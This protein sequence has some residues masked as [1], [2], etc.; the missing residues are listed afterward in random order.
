VE[1]V[2][3]ITSRGGFAAVALSIAVMCGQSMAD[4]VSRV[5]PVMALRSF[6]VEAVRLAI[7]D[8]TSTFGVKYPSGRRSL[9]DLDKL[10]AVRGAM[11]KS[12]DS[13]NRPPAK[14]VTDMLVR[15]RR[16]RREALL[17]NP[18]LEFDKLMLLKRRRGQ[19][20]LPVNHMCNSGLKP[21]GYDNEIAVLSPVGP[22]GKLDTLYR[23][24]GGE[25]VGEIDLHLN[26]DRLLFTMP[27]GKAWQV[28][29]INT[30]GS[31]LRQVSRGKDVGVD[32]FDAC[33]LPDGRIVFASTASWHAVPCWHGKQR[34]CSLY[35]MKADSSAVRQLCFDQDLDLHPAVLPSG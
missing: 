21:G 3:K 27:A 25:Y 28:F 13:G 31:G 10:A 14:A 8:I 33:Y 11:L 5:D 24:K 12:F 30:N 9:A 19:L 18:L 1:N 35:Q 22:G 4:R 26:A 32:S 16:V 15:L 7:K 6:D 17:A 2:S 20:G 23:P 34:A 29:E